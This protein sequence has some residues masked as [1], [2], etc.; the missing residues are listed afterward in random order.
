MI[1]NLIELYSK[2]VE[3]YESIKSYKYLYFKKKMTE[4]FTNETFT[5]KDPNQETTEN[6]SPITKKLKSKNN[7]ERL[8]ALKVK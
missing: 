4:I 7:D 6:D 8:E 2:G 3:Y 1:C 5:S